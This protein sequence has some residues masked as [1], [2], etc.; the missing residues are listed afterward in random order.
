MTLIR[1]DDGYDDD[2]KFIPA[3]DQD[4][5]ERALEIYCADK[6]QSALDDE[7]WWNIGRSASIRAR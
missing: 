3:V 7:E 2:Y 1:P 5:I 6:D 4:A